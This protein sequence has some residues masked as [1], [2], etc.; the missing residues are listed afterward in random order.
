MKKNKKIKEK[1][2]ILKQPVFAETLRIEIDG[3]QS[4]I[5]NILREQDIKLS[6]IESVSAAKMRVNIP[7]KYAKKTFAILD[8][9][10]YN[11]T[12][13]QSFG[14]SR[15]FSWWLSRV[16]LILGLVCFSVLLA[17][18][19]GFIWRINIDTGEKVSKDAI[20]KTL[21]THNIFVGGTKNNIDKRYLR[22][23]LNSIDNVLECSI[24]LKGNTL[25]IKII[26]S[27]DYLAPDNDNTQSDMVSN[28]DAIVT[29][30]VVNSGTANVQIGDKIAKGHTLI[31]GYTLNSAGE[32]ISECKAKGKVYGTVIFSKSKIFST[33]EYKYVLTG[34]KKTSTSI[35]LF[36][37]TIKG[38]AVGFNS[39][40]SETKSGY[41]ANGLFFP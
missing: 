7:K 22:G 30:V 33:T 25:N 39:C 1:K 31:S 6:N 12:V 35:N 34:K 29:K 5:L 21:K 24:E 20:I 28:Y 17:L 10:C 36:G 19:N 18:S 15:M 4:R 13:V 11:Y 32:K 38:K 8:K 3:Q 26:E 27:T 40:V 23:V 9:L 16:G 14:L 2:Y 41:T 37:W